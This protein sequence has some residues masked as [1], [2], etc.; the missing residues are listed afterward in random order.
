[1]AAIGAASLCGYTVDVLA[2]FSLVAR[3][4][5]GRGF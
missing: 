1:M 2:E 3:K 4:D 5:R